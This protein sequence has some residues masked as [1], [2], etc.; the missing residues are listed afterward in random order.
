[1]ET[2]N[3]TLSSIYERSGKE[4]VYLYYEFEEVVL[5]L[6][7]DGSDFVK[8]K[9]EKEFLAKQGSGVLQKQCSIQLK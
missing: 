7:V 8:F 9:G 5:R 1:M 6:Q 4:T 3:I 2:K